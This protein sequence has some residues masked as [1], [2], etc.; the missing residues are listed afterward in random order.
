M[1]VQNP[2]TGIMCS[3]YLSFLRGSLPCWMLVEMLEWLVHLNRLPH[4]VMC[5]LLPRHQPSWLAFSNDSEQVQ[6]R[7]LVLGSGR[8][9]FSR[10][11][12]SPQDPDCWFVVPPESP[13]CC[14]KAPLFMLHRFSRVPRRRT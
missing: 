7:Y 9:T 11:S 8:I 13:T 14:A 1:V 12:A 4:W 10:I 6:G 2:N 3:I 5:I